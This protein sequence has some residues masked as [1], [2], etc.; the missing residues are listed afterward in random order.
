MPPSE[1]V[2]HLPPGLNE[3]ILRLMAKR[4]RDRIGHADDVAAVLEEWTGS[5][6]F[7]DDDGMTGRGAGGR[8]R[9]YLYRPELVG[10]EEVREKLALKLAAAESGMG[11]CV[12]LGGESGVGKTAL[13]GE[14]TRLA[15]QRGMMVMAGECQSLAGAS[16][17]VEGAGGPL[18]P[19]RPMLQTVA[20]RCMERGA[21]F[22]ARLFGGRGTVLAAIEPSLAR[23]TSHEPRPAELPP[24]AARR[25]LL[26]TLANTIA[27]LAEDKPLL[28]VLDDLQWADELTLE[29]LSSLTPDWFDGR[30]V[31]LVATY[32][33]DE[34]SSMLAEALAAPAADRVE[35]S[36]LD[37]RTVE[38]MV[39]DMLALHAPPADFVDFLARASEG[40]PFFVAE[41]LR[42]AVAEGM[43]TRDQ[44]GHWR[45][46]R[47]GDGSERLKLSLPRG[48][49]ELVGQ[50]LA[51]LPEL[52]LRLV[53]AGA[54]LGREFEA[55]LMFQ[56][57]GLSE[58]DEG[59]SK[60]L[61][62][63][64]VRH[65]VETDGAELRFVHDKLR[66]VAYDRLSEVERRTL[67]GAAARAILARHGQDP[68]HFAEL[69]HHF[70]L[71]GDHEAA[72]TYLER[73]GE[74][75]LRTLAHSAAAEAFQRALVLD[76][77]HGRMAGPRR[78]ARWEHGMSKAQFALGDLILAETHG[79]AALAQLG[80][81]LP[82]SRAGWGMLLVGEALRQ[83][84]RV[85]APRRAD[86]VLTPLEREDLSEAAHAASLMT[87]RFYYVGDSAAMVGA[88]LMSVNLAERVSIGWQVPRS[89]SWLGYVVGLLRQHDL[90]GRYFAR[91]HEGAE[92]LDDPSELAFA[93]TVKAV[94]HIGFAHWDPAE[95]S[96][97]RALTLSESDVQLH[98]LALTVL[99]HIEF[100]TGRFEASRQRYVEL[101]ASARARQN[102]QHT[103]W[104]LFSMGRALCAMERFDEARPLLEDARERLAKKSELDSEIICQGLLALTH[105]RRG[106]PALAR[107]LAEETL[108]CVRR[109][110]PGGFAVLGGYDA[111][112]E[113]FLTLWERSTAARG[114]PD[115][116]LV[117]GAMDM[118]AALAKLARLFPLAG[119]ATAFHAGRVERLR[120]HERKALRKLGEAARL[121]DRLGMPHERAR[122]ILAANPS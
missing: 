61:R 109:S 29:L 4:P 13:A 6:H 56:V 66:E 58:A 103:T 104:A 2:D 107:K 114:R 18:H 54:V 19:F 121:A 14:L 81:P 110:R 94:Y 15:A 30:R 10:R 65:V 106:E 60:A 77:E 75:A 45:F 17:A 41:Y 23:V 34:I 90:A 52:G 28:L 42:A 69:A 105:L 89:Y 59:A 22:C 85:V 37:A 33:S 91:A 70:Q 12:Y 76:A 84:W 95:T 31:L 64:L 68:Q 87:H 72:L 71:T 50:R 24:E 8:A 5:S 51:G 7:L 117:R 38:A 115:E 25:R 63:L 53:Q 112:L 99:G 1:L 122:A 74:H 21:E 49:R 3:L 62:D 36:R 86:A 118:L 73:T 32:R 57:G 101:L 39:G 113:V 44:G 55:D 78:R 100:F 35:L 93:L 96:V 20:D 98:E 26:S 11:G 46:L 111:A 119:P 116:G 82:S 102:D 120:G 48:L 27:Q 47:V 92:R 40:N 97:Q 80:R 16:S 67:H 79:R 9:A 88:S 108:A 83:T 43:L